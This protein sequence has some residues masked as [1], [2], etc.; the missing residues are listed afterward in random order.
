MATK[1]L[2]DLIFEETKDA[3]QELGTYKPEF[4]PIIGIYSELREQYEII[5]ERFEHNGYRL[6]TKSEKG[7]MKKSPVIATLENLRKDIL[8]YSDRLC[9]NPKALEGAKVKAAPAQS[10]LDAALEALSRGG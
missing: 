5:T 10:K 3:M 4:D 6:Q 2:K 9:L 1:Q 7:G 8:A